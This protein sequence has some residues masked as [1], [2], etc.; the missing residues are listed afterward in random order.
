M[1][2]THCWQAARPEQTQQR[3]QTTSSMDLPI[4]VPVPVPLPGHPG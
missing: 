2:G 3:V 1:P 4:S